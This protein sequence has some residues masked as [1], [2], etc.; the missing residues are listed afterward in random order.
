[1][2]DGYSFEADSD[3]RALGV[4]RERAWA[5]TSMAMLGLAVTLIHRQA[6][7]ALAVTVSDSL[8]ISHVAYGALSSA[9]A[10]AYLVGSVPGARFMQ[11][12][13]PRVGLAATLV[14]TSIAIGL[15]GVVTS[16]TTLF[17]LRICLGL[18]VAPAFACATHTVHRVL[19]FKDRARGIGLLYMGN[20]LGSAVC[21]P[22]AVTLASHYGWRNAFLGVAVIGIVWV[23]LW[24]AMAFTGAARSRLDKGSMSPPPMTRP[25]LASLPEAAFVGKA[26]RNP[27]VFRGSFVVAAAAPVT[28]VMLLWGT[29]YLVSDH[30]LTQ[31]Q[32][33][34]YLWLPALL[35]GSGSMLFAEL[36]A[37]TARSRAQTR[38]PRVLMGIA[39]VLAMLM[40]AVPLA[41]GTLACIIIAS[42]A[43]CG[44][45]GLYTL[46]TSDMLA[47]APRGSVPATTGL[48]TLTQSLVYIVVS[49]IIGKSVEMSGNYRD[50]L[51]GAGLWVLPGCVFWLIHASL[52]RVK[53]K[54]DGV[55]DK[56]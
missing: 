49:P 30:G 23:P 10:S 37:R 28:T 50:V 3:I 14:L 15:H 9:F 26:F 45:G 47:F 25:K 5:L 22:L 27:A 42:L 31:A 4:S 32:T 34:H 11:Q 29:K 8:V 12:F 33:G 36:R 20:S 1:L 51:V 21:P 39:M 16:Y 6:L 2:R 24:I 18:A 38:P 17:I 13:G 43:M 19:P 41:H 35:F 7:A 55:S 54:K 48:T 53:P 56:V 44:A 46:A 52:T 40:A